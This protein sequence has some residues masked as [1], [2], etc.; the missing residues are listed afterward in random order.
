MG[1]LINPIQFRLGYSLFYN[2]NWPALNKE[3]YMLC[4]GIQKDF[5]DY[6]RALFNLRIKLILKRKNKRRKYFTKVRHPRLL[7]STCNVNFFGFNLHRVLVD[8]NIFDLNFE[9]KWDSLFTHK[10]FQTFLFRFGKIFRTAKILRNP[11][12]FINIKKETIKKF[13]LILNKQYHK[14][15]GTLIS[16]T[17]KWVKSYLSK[18]YQ[19]FFAFFN[20]SNFL[21]N[22]RKTLRKAKQY[23]KKRSSKE[24][25]FIT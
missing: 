3:Q 7:F 5:Y 18:V 2:R 17:S 9:S 14:V 13:F 12:F 6:F 25:V 21:V 15:N 22:K 11:T 20:D 16:Q 1:H 8:V 24:H 19:K 10:Q 4:Y 23:I